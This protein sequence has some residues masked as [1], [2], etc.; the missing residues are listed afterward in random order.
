MALD[1]SIGAKFAAL[2]RARNKFNL[3]IHKEMQAERKRAQRAQY[4]AAQSGNNGMWGLAATGA[5]VGSMFLPGAGTAIG[6]GIGMGVGALTEGIQNKRTADQYGVKGYGAGDAFKD[7]LRPP[8]TQEAGMMAMSAAQMGAAKMRAQPVNP[9]AGS[10]PGDLPYI[11]D[12]QS[13][14][15]ANVPGYFDPYAPSPTDPRFWKAP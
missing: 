6:A 13:M 8:S 4:E 3:G 9:A 15:G 12:Q 11:Y 10:R 14:L 2:A 5:A 7:L 1:P